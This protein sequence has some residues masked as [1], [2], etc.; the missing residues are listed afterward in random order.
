M[1]STHKEKPNG[2]S[3]VDE[4]MLGRALKKTTQVVLIILKK[5]TKWKKNLLT[6]ELC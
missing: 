4:Q 3:F 5:Q 1:L 2:T 6:W